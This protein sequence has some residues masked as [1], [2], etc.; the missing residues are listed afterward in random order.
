MDSLW[1][2]DSIPSGDWLARILVGNPT[3]ILRAAQH[4]PTMW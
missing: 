2:A 1:Q 4:R 3:E